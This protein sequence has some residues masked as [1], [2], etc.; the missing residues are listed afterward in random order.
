MITQ[1][2]NQIENINKSL[3]WIKKNKPQDYDQK[4]L[5]FVEE[6]RKLRRLKAA[7]Q[8]NPAIAA[9]G[10][11]QVGKSYLMNCLLQKNGERFMIDGDGIRYNFIEEMNPKTSDT[12]ATGVVTR[13]TSFNNNEDRYS[14]EYPILMRCLSVAD[15]IMVI[16]DGYYYDIH[17]YTTYSDDEIKQFI[18]D[19]RNHYQM[20]PI[21]NASPITADDILDIK[22]YFSKHINNAQCFLHT[23]FFDV[24]ALFVN[25]IPPTDW[26]N[27]F[28]VLWH[29]SPYQNKL[30]TKMLDTLAKL[31]YNEF[32]YLPTQS[33]LHGGEN[34]NTI[35]S[36][37]CLNGLFNSS[38]QY[39]TNAYLR[40][41][42]SYTKVS[43][44]TKS[45][46]CAVCSEIIVKVGN[47]YLENINCYNLANIND[48]N[49]IKI[50]SKGRSIVR[51]EFGDDVIE[52]KT[53]TLRVNDLLDFPGARSR[54]KELLETLEKDS[55]LV[56][57]LLRGKVAY[58]FNLYNESRR[59]NILLY[60][61]HAAQN[62]V[63]DIP[64]LLSDWIKNYVGDTME[65]RKKTIELTAGISPLFYIGTKF[66]M[67]MALKGEEIENSI[68]GLN[69]RW[70]ARFEKVLYHQCFNADGSF[71]SEKNLQFLNWTEPGQCFSNSYVLR[72]FKFSYNPSR[73]YENEKTKEKKMILPETFYNDLRNTFCSNEHV[74]RFFPNP[75]LSWD[76]AASIDN[77]G[78]L[79]IIEQLAKVANC[80]NKLRDEQF[81]AIL[82]K[83][84][85]KV[86]DVMN[87]YHISTNV[88]EL[89][90]CNIR[91]AKA[92]FREMDFTCNS[93]NYYF[94]NLI[95][96]LQITEPES[97]KIVHKVIESP[98]II[99]TVNDFKDYEIIRS[100]CENSGFPIETAKD[101]AEKWQCIIKTYGFKTQSDAE[102]FLITKHI[103]IKKLFTGSFKRKLN[104]CV[105]ADAVYNYWCTK[106]KSVDFLHEFTADGNFDSAIM[107]S[108][109]DQMISVSKTINVVD[110]MAKLISD[111]V[112]VIDIHTAN[113]NL[114]SDML[115]DVI[116]D[117]VLDFGYEFLSN[118]DRTKAK[119][120]CKNWNI[121]AFNFIERELPGT[122]GEPELTALFNDMSTNPKSL[123]PSFEDNY[124]KWLEFMFISFVS[125]LEIPDFDREANLVLEELLKKIKIA[126]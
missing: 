76:V 4:F 13:F 81:G 96:A 121:P 67:D 111:Y 21:I 101:D 7:K 57:V 70:K 14:S 97:Y 53:D 75:E 18:T 86:L 31:Q 25:R 113:K 34:E 8:D 42:N 87:D 84:T 55:V 59:I 106:I 15:I 120:V 60:C 37:Q 45:E 24:L 89:L 118:E 43:D 1:I 91:K 48:H 95:Q 38:P 12:E 123:L 69:G 115:A 100:S 46:I 19:F 79:F 29:Q 41:D 6:R 50:L 74:K 40:H 16:S 20:M 83:S 5:Q 124:H 49:V 88:D 26:E 112:N 114:I 58:L 51:N 47:E 126:S 28:S 122:I 109:V 68:N 94:G 80:M 2:N 93:D 102:E 61:H 103:D 77:D 73:L 54:K 33:M 44:L 65:K 64:L 39:F 30:F 90:E 71:D 119:N 23:G 17:D 3:E 104:S 10:I 117:F 92:I 63:N 110:R 62:E 82:S 32:V 125:N 72:D 9:Y 11:S 56:N 22:E 66:N 52:V 116:Q 105:I 78:A 107:T 36:V 98:E 35:M 108:L 85:R 99:G 27:V